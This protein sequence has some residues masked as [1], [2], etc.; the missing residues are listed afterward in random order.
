MGRIEGM[1]ESSH[2]AE[3]EKSKEV[4]QAKEKNHPEVSRSREKPESVIEKARA[5]RS[6][7]MQRIILSRVVSGAKDIL[8]SPLF[9][10]ALNYMP[11]VGDVTL[12][13]GVIQGKEGSRRL[14]AGERLNYTA[15][16]GM[17]VLSYFHLNEGNL[18]AAGIDQAILY[19]MLNIDMVPLA[20]KKTAAALE[21][22][23]PKLAHM[24]NAVGDYLLRKRE[25]LA[26]L[27]DLLQ[28]NPPVPAPEGATS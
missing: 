28:K 19:T 8:T 26:N 23:T 9:L 11:V 14:T 3:K 10:K 25:Q 7:L 4:R 1:P 24:M 5:G 15:A 2:L 13:R 27:K 16:F 18:A 12:A 20:I 17:A 6:D 22:K 21:T